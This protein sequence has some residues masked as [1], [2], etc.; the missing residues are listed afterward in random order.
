MCV[1]IVALTLAAVLGRSRRPSLNQPKLLQHSRLVPLFP[2]F[3]DYTIGKLVDDQSID[4][5]RSARRGNRAE[6]PRV[7]T[8]RAPSQRD[9]VA[10][11]E[12]I[13]HREVKV[14]K[15]DQ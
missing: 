9:P 11:P 8:R 13:L 6:R 5:H 3:H 14:W 15:C 2:P 7:G 4:L 1:T 10:N 12:L